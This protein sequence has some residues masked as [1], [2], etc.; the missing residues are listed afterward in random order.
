[1]MSRLGLRSSMAVS[2]VVVS[3]IAVFVVEAVALAVMLPRFVAARD[4]VEQARQQVADAEVDAARAKAERLAV[5]TPAAVDEQVSRAPVNPGGTDAELLMTLVRGGGLSK[6]LNS[7]SR[8]ELLVALTDVNGFILAASPASL[9]PTGTAVWNAAA[10]TSVR[11]GRTTVDGQ[12][13]GWAASPV[14]IRMQN[15]NARFVGAVYV[16]LI[17]AK[18]FADAKPGSASAT[19]GFEGL[20]IPGGIV[21]LMLVPVGALFGLLSTGPLIRRIRR[22]ADGTAAMAG[23]DLRIR[24]P[25]TGNDEVARLERSFNAM[26]ER[27]EEA[28]ASDRAAAG[29]QARRA[30]RTRITRELHDSV[31]QDLFS[32][33]LLAG[34]LRKALPA[35]SELRHQAASLEASLERTKREMRA[36]LLELRPVALED[37][38]LSEALDELC[39]AYQERLGIAVT[40]RV[41]A[42]HLDPPVEHAVLRVVQEALGNAVRHGAPDTVELTVTRAAGQVTVTVHDD[43]RGFDPSEADG[44]HGMGI[45]LMRDRVRELGGMVDVVSAPQAGTTVKV[46]LPAGAA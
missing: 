10:C 34:G 21:M 15:D 42:G 20:L 39:R 11:S 35:G 26:A 46:L 2:Y 8:P 23:G 22:L 28:V 18:N 37:A 4:S 12:P 25:V 32:A 27:L 24:L 6:D 7:D 16:R 41:E 17:V 30:E 13:A 14:Q 19:A 33:S 5:A 43:G 44:R 40:A 31:S 3:A 1:M 29:A 36:M 45:Q 9:L 38:G